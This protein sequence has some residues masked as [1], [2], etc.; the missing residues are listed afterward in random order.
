MGP[1]SRQGERGFSLIELMVAM[2]AT[3]VVSGAVYGLLTAGNTAFRREPALADRQQNIRAALDMIGSDVF[4]A[5]F[6]LPPFAQAFTDGLDA[7]GPD[8]PGGAKTDEI[9]IFAA[10]DCPYLGICVI[11]PQGTGASVTTFQAL[12]ACYRF[13]ALVILGDQEKWGLYWAE[14]PGTAVSGACGPGGGVNGH[15]TLPHGQEP[16]INPPGGLGTWVPE[17]MMVGQAIRYRITVDA[18]GTPNLERSDMGGR[19][20]PDGSSSWQTIARGIEDLQVEYENGVDWEDTPGVISCGLSCATPTTAEYDTIV[21]RVRIR[22]SA[23]STEAAL[24]GQTTSAVGDAVRGQLVTDI[25]PRAA[26][27]TLGMA[28]GEI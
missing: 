16:L 26:N 12:S 18:E 6:G 15:V 9:E 11:T 1:E 14:K 4:R 2:V 13:P 23:R 28:K 25:A 8:G 21:R 10:A 27:S 19:P 22:L 3:L 20:L 7:Q 5:G 17:Y 24:Q